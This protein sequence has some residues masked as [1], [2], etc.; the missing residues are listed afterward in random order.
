MVMI[1][2]T[3][4]IHSKFQGKLNIVLF[5]LFFSLF[6]GTILFLN[7]NV[8]IYK[9]KRRYISVGIAMGYRLDGRGSIPGRGKISFSSGRPT[10]PSIQWVPGAIS[11]RVYRPGREADHSLPSSAEVKN[12]G[13]I[14]PLPR[15][16]SWHS[17]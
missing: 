15:T 5:T 17:A 2:D 9:K 3:S 4:V 16:T 6:S 11:L 14:P 7:F 8:C 13:V 1:Y 10:H 12:S